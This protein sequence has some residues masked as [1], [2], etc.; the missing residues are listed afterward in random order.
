MRK[1][2]LFLSLL[3]TSHFIFSQGISIE[4]F[5]RL[6]A[7]GELPKDLLNIAKGYNFDG[8]KPK[9]NIQKESNEAVKDLILSGKILYGDTV[10][11]YLENVLDNLLSNDPSLRKQIRIY[12]IKSYEVN[13][14]MNVDGFLF[15][16]VGFIAQTTS[17]AEIAFVLS[18]E[19]IHYVKQHSYSKE[20]DKKNVL[21]GI[22]DYLKYHSRSREQEFECDKL[23][24]ELYFKNSSYS[25]RAIEGMFDVLQYSYLPFD[26]LKVNRDIFENDY[27][28]FKD[29]YILENLTPITSREDY[30][31][32]F[33]TH[34][35]IKS[36]R[37]EMEKIMRAN[38]H[39]GN[40]DFIQSKEAYY[41]VRT[42]ARFETINQQ[43][44]SD[45]Y[46]KSF[47]NS[48]IL[49]KEY[50]NNQFLLTSKIASIYGIS[51]VKTHG[52]YTKYLH[53][54]KN[55]EG[56]MQFVAYLFEKM[57]K[58]ETALMALRY[59]WQGIKDLDNKKY[60]TLLFQ[61]I[62]N[63]L[64]SEMN[65]GSLSSFS[66]YKMG[67]EISNEEQAS[68]DTITSKNQTKYDK[69]KQK[70]L[71]GHQPKFK[72]E[73]YMLGD[74]KKEE[75][76]VKAFDEAL[77]FNES[78]KAKRIISNLTK[79]NSTN[80]IAKVLVFE[81]T[82]KKFKKD[83]SSSFA[84][85]KR[86]SNIFCKQIGLVA[87]SCNIETK[88]IHPYNYD[89]TISY[90]TRARLHDFASGLNKFGEIYYENRDIDNLKQSIGTQYIN[91]ISYKKQPRLRKNAFY[92][93]LYSGL[94]ISLY[95]LSPIAIMQ[96]IPNKYDGSMAFLM[97]DIEKGE[98]SSFAS[99]DITYENSRDV[100]NETLYKMYQ[101]GRKTNGYLGKR[102]LFSF[103][104]R[105]SP[106]WIFPN[107][108]NQKGG[109]KFNYLFAPSFEYVLNDKFT[110]GT[111]YQF[112]KTKFS[113]KLMNN[114]FFYQ[115][116]TGDVSVSG[117][118]IFMR[119]YLGEQAPL[120]YYYKYQID[121]FNYKVIDSDWAFGMR[122]EFG[123]TLFINKYISLGTGLS[124]GLL[125]DG[126]KSLGDDHTEV[127]INDY[128]ATKLLGMYAIGLNFSIG[129]LPF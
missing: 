21:S 123:K 11:K 98:I 69:V 19:L 100:E 16:N 84:T 93:L 30:I 45:I 73:N 99:E 120:G 104:T 32:T 24:Y 102:F 38:S 127:S 94:S 89:S 78:K 12:A 66:D 126:F 112:F 87:K 115:H 121:A 76:F 14:F 41:F 117:Y 85:N 86:L 8:S 2:I 116:Y 33:S 97:Y 101:N 118:N 113:Y 108:N 23:G 52:S 40:N 49:D 56:Q 82:A 39:L 107:Y 36:R 57:N 64:Q 46:I 110:I 18:H 34:P 1:I 4:R 17:E 15:V 109:F 20:K 48:L 128:A 122:I 42:I 54:K 65:L 106:A 81:P 77:T 92:K 51:K 43:I 103:D 63:D 29:E 71:V 26:E 68:E 114:N 88:I 27:Y 96:W 58:K 119:G 129:I 105:L 35:N 55:T 9:N 7:V 25:N 61:D 90:Q 10:T 72:T 91:L 44:Q 62:V 37:A 74:L 111:S 75:A 95:P 3:I 60:F 28:K 47:Y 124:A 6:E 125:F 83:N 59:C 31:D 79:D 53:S 5:S 50:P 70:Q 80:N 67:E 13:A 22:D